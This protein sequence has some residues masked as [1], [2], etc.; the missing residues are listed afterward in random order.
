MLSRGC[1]EHGNDEM[2]KNNE[3]ERKSNDLHIQ[4]LMNHKTNAEREKGIHSGF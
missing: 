2:L 4:M 1:I 3:I